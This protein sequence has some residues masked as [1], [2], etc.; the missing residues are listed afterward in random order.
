MQYDP[1]KAKIGKLVNR[2]P[3]MRRMFYGLLDRLLLRTWH[4]KRA[5]REFAAQHPGKA[6]IFDAGSGFG[7]YSYR[8]WKMNSSWSIKAID[9]KEEQ[10]A[11]CKLFFNKIGAAP[12]VSFET[13][14]LT[15]YKS[16][17]AYNLILSVD[18]M[19]HIEE[20]EKVFGN[21][22]ESLAPGG[23]LIISTPSDKGGSDV[24]HDHDESFID[25]HVRDGYGTDEI[26][27]K[28][29]RAGFSNIETKYTYGRPGN[30][31]WR[32]SMKYPIL[33]L[34]K[35][36]IF[37]IILPVWYIIFAIPCLILNYRDV[38]ILHQEG[39]GLLVVARKDR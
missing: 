18:V 26:R 28:L 38:K 5:L 17:G 24:K 29:Q 2:A 27:N 32:L 34:N 31:S 30:I 19:E 9:L 22:H 20:D 13:G 21:F 10:I 1:V 3:W 25:E 11:D 12:A 37:A 7:Q 33:M 36:W 23:W 15:R 4:V 6:S 16:E 14:D 8:M 39:S 35:S